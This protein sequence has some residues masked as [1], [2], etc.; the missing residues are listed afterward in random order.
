M[1]FQK[2]R[3]KKAALTHFTKCEIWH[4]EEKYEETLFSHRVFFYQMEWARRRT[5]QPFWYLK[6]QKEKKLP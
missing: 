3:E 6:T 4:T 2:A 5:D 1:P